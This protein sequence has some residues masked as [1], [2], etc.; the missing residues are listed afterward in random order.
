MAQNNNIVGYALMPA[1]GAQQAPPAGQT[2][3]LLLFT[4][5]EEYSHRRPDRRL[6]ND[7]KLSMAI[8]HDPKNKHAPY[9]FVGGMLSKIRC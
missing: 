8:P 5:V 7:H 4:L 3:H 9:T 1:G 2:Y 6:I